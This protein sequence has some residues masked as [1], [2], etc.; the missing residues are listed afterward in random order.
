[1][2]SGFALFIAF[3]INVAIVSVSSTICLANNLSDEIVNQCNIFKLDSAPFLLKELKVQL[4]LS[5]SHRLANSQQITQGCNCVH[6]DH[7]TFVEPEKLDHP[8]TQDN[9]E[10]GQNNSCGVDPVD[11]IPY[12][13]FRRYPSTR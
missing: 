2:G 8:V 7:I 9:M 6:W 3:L 10:H 4:N 13:G 1:M 5:S 11:H 12:R